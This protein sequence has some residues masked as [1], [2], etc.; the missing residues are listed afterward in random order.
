MKGNHSTRTVDTIMLHLI[1]SGNRRKLNVGILSILA[2][3]SIIALCLPELLLFNNNTKQIDHHRKVMSTN[4]IIKKID[5]LAHIK[6]NNIDRLRRPRKRS[7]TNEAVDKL[8]NSDIPKRL[9][10]VIDARATSATNQQPIA[11]YSLANVLQTVPYF[12]DTFAVLIY[13]PP[14]D[15][16]IAHY[17]NNMRWISGC[18]KLVTSLKILANSLRILFPDRFN[19]EAPEFA[20]AMSSADYPGIKWN[21]CL[22]DQ[23]SDCINAAGDELELSPILQFGSNFRRSVFPTMITM[24]MPQMNHLSCYHY[25][26]LHHQICH[27]YLPRTLGN[28]EGLVFAETIGVKSWDELI[29]QVVWRGTDFSY[30]HKMEPSL[31][32]PNFDMDVASQLD[33]SGKVDQRTAATHAI[34]QVYEELIPRWKGVVWTAEAEREAEA[35]NNRNLK[36]KKKPA[37]PEQPP[38]LPWANIKF[39]SAMYMG[40]KTPTSEIEYYK[41][42]E[43]YGIPAIGERMSL[44][45]LGRY[46]Y[47]VDLGGGGGTTWS[48]TIEKLSMP[49][50][51]FHHVT[52]TKDYLHDK[53]VPWAHYVPIKADLSDLR[54]K[55]EWAESH[56]REARKIAE[57][58]TEF[59]RYL[60]SE[61]GFARLYQEHVVAPLGNIITAYQQP[62]KKYKG[63][64]LLDILQD[65][66][67]KGVK[68][69]F[70]VVARCG[71]WPA[72]SSEC[73]WTTKKKKKG[74]EG[75][76]T[77][78]GVAAT[79]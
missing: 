32:P 10:A 56:P 19:A 5:Y 15:K 33:L 77:A 54:E 63:R 28:P 22:L 40:K 27:Y 72:E 18:H 70:G 9:P 76:T 43:V 46:R 24:P 67:F 79:E 12:H 51:L 35:V 20:L 65:S 47:H 25:W 45:T 69:E 55:Y 48:G 39:A 4:S 14:T 42:F 38:V 1:S 75:T 53:M 74:E 17:S 29:P 6:S 57:A 49:G 23:R 13:D 16:F 36:G 78:S 30:L 73:R 60:G 2:L 52:P 31:R 34:R 3:L 61:E 64:R 62:R 44:E 50:L 71:G 58:G 11:P 7:L 37:Q 8:D 21:E 59:A 41:Q 26:A 66:E 68:D